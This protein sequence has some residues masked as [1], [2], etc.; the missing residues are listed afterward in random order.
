MDFVNVMLGIALV[1]AIEPTAAAARYD[2]L[3]AT[4]VAADWFSAAVSIHW[5]RWTHSFKT[6]T[7]TLVVPHIHKRPSQ[8][9]TF[10]EYVAVVVTD[11]S[12]KY[13]FSLCIYDISYNMLWIQ[14][15]RNRYTW[16]VR[17][18]FVCCRPMKYNRKMRRLQSDVALRLCVCVCMCT[19]VCCLQHLIR[20][21]IS[22]VCVE[23]VCG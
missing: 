21:D 9:Q 23:W 17:H 1:A 14:W 5:A 22:I 7:R 20:V 6:S 19:C 2:S 4:V 8:F 11:A 16:T 15:N 3:T 13:S 18:R 10:H 12:P